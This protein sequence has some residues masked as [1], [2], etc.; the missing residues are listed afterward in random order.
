M[1]E[2]TVYE[3]V[4]STDDAISGFSVWLNFTKHVNSVSKNLDYDT[5]VS[6]IDKELLKW[7]GS[8]RQLGWPTKISFP[9]EESLV[10]FQLAWS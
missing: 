7:K 9:D 4:I 5:Y 8:R 1:M 3:M 10:A 6:M 2:S